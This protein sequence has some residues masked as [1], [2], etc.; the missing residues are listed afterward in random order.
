LRLEEEFFQLLVYDVK[1][2]RGKSPVHPDHQVKR[3]KFV[4]MAPEQFPYHALR[5]IPRDRSPQHPFSHNH[6][7][8]RVAGLVGFCHYLQMGASYGAPET[9]NG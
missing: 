9:K 6:A 3:V 4:L 5:V 1:V 7:E 2:F 8:T